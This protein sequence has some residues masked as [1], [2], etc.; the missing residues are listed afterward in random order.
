MCKTLRNVRDD[1]DGCTPFY[2]TCY[3]NN[4][5]CVKKLITLE[6]FNM[7]NKNG[8]SPFGAAIDEGKYKI[9]N[10]L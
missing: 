7:R 1:E 3:Y 6:N 4:L 2:M 5:K 10:F 8:W 9:T